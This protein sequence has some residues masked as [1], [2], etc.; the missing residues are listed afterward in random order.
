MQTNG[1]LEAGNKNIKRILSKMVETSQDQ[2]KNLSSTLW[3]F[4]TYF[5]TFTSATPCS[6]VYGVEVMLP[7]KIEMGSLRVSLEQQIFQIRWAQAR[8]DQ[9][10][11]LDERRLRATDHIHTYQ[12]KMAHAFKKQVKLRLLQR[13]DLVLR[14]LQGLVGD[15]KKKFKPSWSGPYIT[16]GLTS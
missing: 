15:P 16:R 5:L 9:L 6:L 1:A 2:F 14:V 8:F 4:S 13:G 7:I 3:E 12:K 10:S 11:L